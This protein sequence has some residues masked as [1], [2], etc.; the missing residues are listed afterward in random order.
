VSTVRFKAFEQNSSNQSFAIA[1]VNE[2]GNGVILS[3]LH[4]RDHVSV[5]AKPV[6]EYASTH[7]LT[8][9]EKSVLTEAKKAH[10]A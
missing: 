10:K 2:L 5:F 8:E 7:D 3:S 9:E 1:L 4:H 6:A